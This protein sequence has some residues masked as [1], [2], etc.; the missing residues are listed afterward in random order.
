MCV[1][2]CIYNVNLLLLNSNC[3][4]PDASFYTATPLSLCCRYTSEAFAN[5]INWFIF[6]GNEA[7]PAIQFDWWD[8]VNPLL[9]LGWFPWI[10]ATMFL[11]GWIHQLRCHA[12]LT[13][14][15]FTLVA[16]RLY[17]YAG[18]VVAS[19]GTDLTIW[20]LLAFVV[21]NLVMAAGETH[22]WYL[23]KFDTYPI[24][25]YVIIPFVY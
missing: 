3:Y 14:G 9:K 15:A 2:I 16:F 8:F 11:W 12:I 17:D 23:H 7:M 19:G 22:M 10:G 20:L 25:R 4:T 18:F 5:V 13:V 21:A 1:D 24:N 6:G